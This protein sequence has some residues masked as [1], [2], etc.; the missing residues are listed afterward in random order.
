MKAVRPLLDSA[1][2]MKTDMI[3]AVIITR[4]ALLWHENECDVLPAIPVRE[5]GNAK[6]F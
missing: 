4:G 5:C 2:G 1:R 3:P 6:M